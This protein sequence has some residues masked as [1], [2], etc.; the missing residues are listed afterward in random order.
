MHFSCSSVDEYDKYAKG[1]QKEFSSNDDSY[2]R[3][4]LKM[5]KTL[6]TIPFIYSNQQLRDRF[7]KT[8]RNNIKMEIE[9]LES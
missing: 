9:N 3:D 8:A 4:R 5:L 6:L 1:V 7:E 2:Q